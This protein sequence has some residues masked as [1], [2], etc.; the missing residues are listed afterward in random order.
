MHEPAVTYGETP[1]P[2]APAALRPQPAAG[3]G[4][5][6]R[7]VALIITIGL[8]WAIVVAV[9]AWVIGLLISRG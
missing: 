7:L 6:G 8:A 5:L 4:P 9:A 1:P 2:T 3:P